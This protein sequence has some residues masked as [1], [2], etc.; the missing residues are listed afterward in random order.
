ML[1]RTALLGPGRVRATVAVELGLG[2]TDRLLVAFLAL[3]VPIAIGLGL[4]ARDRVAFRRF[5]FVVVATFLA[6]Y[7]GYVVFPTLGPRATDGAHVGGGAISRALRAFIALAE[8]NRLDAFPSGHTAMALV[9][10][11]LGWSAFPRGRPRAAR[12]PRRRRSA[13]VVAGLPAPALPCDALEATRAIAE[14]AVDRPQMTGRHEP[15]GPP[16]RDAT[17]ATTTGPVVD[18]PEQ[19]HVHVLQQRCRQPRKRTPRET[20]LDRAHGR[21]DPPRPEAVEPAQHRRRRVGAVLRREEPP[22]H[23]IVRIPRRPLARTR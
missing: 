4:Y 17:D 1:G 3:L 19:Q 14:H 22:P 10:I 12:P 6:S 11:G 20:A 15:A 23:P 13:P 2:A 16:R 7:L 18:V 8:G 21:R 5:V 9:C